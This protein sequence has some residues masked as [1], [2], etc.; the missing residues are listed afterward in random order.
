[1]KNI[2]RLLKVADQET[3]RV[4]VELPAV[5]VDRLKPFGPRFIKVEPPKANDKSSG[6][7]AVE[8]EWQKQPYYAED[9]QFREWLALGGNYGILAGQ[10]LIIIETDEIG[11]AHV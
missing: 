6:K 8:R 5:L 10:G 3:G 7:A 11:R 4:P 2:M 1:M 9:T